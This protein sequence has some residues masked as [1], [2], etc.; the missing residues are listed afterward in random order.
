MKGKAVVQKKKFF[1]FGIV[2]ILILGIM[3]SYIYINYNNSSNL[4]SKY[5]KATLNSSY[6]PSGMN[7]SAD[8]IVKKAVELGN[9]TST[10]K[11]Y[12]AGCI[13]FVNE[14]IK[15]V[16]PNSSL[17]NG[18]S[19]WGNNSKINGISATRAMYASARNIMNGS[20]W[21]NSLG[22][23]AN[24][25]QIGDIIIGDGHAMIYLGQASSYGELN[26]KLQEQYGVQF[27]GLNDWTANRGSYYRDYLNKPGHETAGCTYWTIDVNGNGGYAR[28]ESYNWTDTSGS[29]GS[30]NLNNM[31]VYRFKNPEGS[32][33]V[34]LGKKSS[35]NLS[36]GAFIGGITFNVKQTIEG[37][38]TKELSPVTNAGRVKN[39]TD[40]VTISSINGYDNY[41][42]AESDS[43]GYI[44]REG[45]YGVNVYKKL[46]G[47][48]YTIDY[49]KYYSGSN[50]TYKSQNIKLGET[51]YILEN[52]DAKKK[53]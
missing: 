24:S 36:D 22:M 7:I 29:A 42:F 8:D 41:I 19:G 37:E 31:K 44:K 39:I 18:C 11:R 16:Q 35:E 1:I 2:A 51:Y 20:S 27:S 49:I 47:N 10:S 5:N 26:T 46:S 40:E 30:W 33:H 53:F 6:D 28:V 50:E 48:K 32:Y 17:Q 15:G 9:N 4:R 52:R 45:A 21:Y 13:G 38:S 12:P 34:N 3:T 23:D 25:L 14:V 43:P